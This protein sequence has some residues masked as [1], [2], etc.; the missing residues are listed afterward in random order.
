MQ[1]A[2]LGVA[3]ASKDFTLFKRDLRNPSQLISPLIIG[4]LFALSILRSGGELPPGRGE[5]PAS[6]TES[7]RA[8]LSHGSVAVSLFV[9]WPLLEGQPLLAAEVRGRATRIHVSSWLSTFTA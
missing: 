7:F 3:I 1:A 8:F 2:G 4:I 6:L 5:V 9:G